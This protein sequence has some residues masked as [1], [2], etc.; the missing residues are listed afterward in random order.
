MM[1]Q[2]ILG[3]LLVGLIGCAGY[4]LP[5]LNYENKKS[6]VKIETNKDGKLCVD[7]GQNQSGCIKLNKKEEE[8]PVD[9][10]EPTKSN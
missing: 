1:K 4:E 6:G 3:L 10:D 9:Q 7:D 2:V 8:G 5:D